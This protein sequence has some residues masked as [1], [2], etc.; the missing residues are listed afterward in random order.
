MRSG[1]KLKKKELNQAMTGNNMEWNSNF[2]MVILSAK[3]MWAS[4]IWAMISC[5]T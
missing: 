1:Q 2:N 4:S 3:Q 5:R